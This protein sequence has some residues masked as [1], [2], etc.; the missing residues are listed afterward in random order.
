MLLQTNIT[1]LQSANLHQ[2]TLNI[3]AFYQY[4]ILV[5]LLPRTELTFK[6]GPGAIQLLE[7]NKLLLDLGILVSQDCGRVLLRIPLNTHVGTDLT[8]LDIAEFGSNLSPEL[9]QHARFN[10]PTHRCEIDEYKSTVRCLCH[11]TGI[12]DFLKWEDLVKQAG[13]LEGGELGES[14][15]PV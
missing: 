13:L 1:L 5:L 8:E 10:V 6:L 2:Q 11:L 9:C 12:I 7:R 14:F 3:Y 4:L 15:L